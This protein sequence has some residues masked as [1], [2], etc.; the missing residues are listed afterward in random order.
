MNITIISSNVI[1][2]H[3]NTTEQLLIWRQTTPTH[4]PFHSPSTQKAT[5]ILFEMFNKSPPVNLH[6]LANMKKKL[7]FLSKI[8]SRY[9]LKNNTAS[10]AFTSLCCYKT[11][12]LVAVN[13]SRVIKTTL[14]SSDIFYLLPIRSHLLNK[15]ICDL[16]YTQVCGLV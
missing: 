15:K 14:M 6:N 9:P 12:L 4:S 1:C 7:I 3:R 5:F 13:Y 8:Q 10:S 2:S 16:S 11:R